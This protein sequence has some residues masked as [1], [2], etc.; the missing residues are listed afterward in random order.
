MIDRTA[1]TR[2]R[3][4]VLALIAAAVIYKLLNEMGAGTSSLMFVGLPAVLAVIVTFAPPSPTATGTVMKV[5]T[6]MMLIGAVLA[7]EGAVCI[8][9]ASPIVYLIGWAV[10]SALDYSRRRADGPVV[11]VAVLV[12]ILVLSVQGVVPGTSGP[13]A[14]H[15]T[16]ERI[17]SMSPAEVEH[18]LRR[19][20]RFDRPLPAL[21]RYGRFPKPLSCELRDGRF[22][23]EFEHGEPANHKLDIGS[24]AQAMRSQLVLEVVESK[25]GRVAFGTV[26]DTTMTSHW[27]DLASSVVEWERVAHGTRVVWSLELRRKLDPFWY[28]GPLQTYAASRTAEYLIDAVVR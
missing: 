6:L 12:P 24:H 25:P 28:F 8:L 14:V 16:A 27:A 11:R 13:R 19:P 18:A 22:V 1:L 20:V 10:G 3:I 26:T 15:A 9:M 2:S 5:L 7:V 23:I 21:F 4:I 17:V